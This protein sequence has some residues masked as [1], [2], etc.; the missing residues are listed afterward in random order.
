M[1]WRSFVAQL[2]LNSQLIE[3]RLIKVGASEFQGKSCHF[4]NQV[5]CQKPN[6]EVTE[7]E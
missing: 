2:A 6:A 7:E 5:F 4:P 1:H 3:N